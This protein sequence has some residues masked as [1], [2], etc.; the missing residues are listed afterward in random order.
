MMRPY[1]RLGYEVLDARMGVYGIQ[2]VVARCGDGAMMTL[3]WKDAKR[4]V[5]AYPTGEV[6]DVHFNMG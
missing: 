4:M 3:Q 5:P 2:I 6:L 1:G